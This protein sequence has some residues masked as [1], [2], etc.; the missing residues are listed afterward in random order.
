MTKYKELLQKH[1]NLRTD[2]NGVVCIGAN[3]EKDLIVLTLDDGG[4]LL[5]SQA[6]S[7][8]LF[9]GIASCIP[10]E[11]KELINQIIALDEK[12]II[13]S[14]SFSG[15]GMGL[16]TV[17]IDG[18]MILSMRNSFM[19]QT[20]IFEDSLEVLPGQTILIEVENISFQN[21]TNEYEAFVFYRK[22]VL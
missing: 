22:V 13:S 19:E 2:L 6:V 21:N 8:N 12:V 17:K 11:K 20:K 9:F 10:N 1:K 15:N 4:N 7:N 18:V 5:L 16:L 3:T 14:F